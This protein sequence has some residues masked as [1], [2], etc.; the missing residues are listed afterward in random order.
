MPLDSET[1]TKEYALGLH[2]VPVAASTTIYSGALVCVN[3]SGNAIPA[4]DA[5]NARVIGRAQETVVNTGL[6]GA[7]TITV[8][9]G[10]FGFKNSASQACTNAHVGRR[11]FVADDETVQS[12][13]GTNSVIAGLMV[14]FEGTDVI[15]DTTLAAAL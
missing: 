11:V 13:T 7:L 2:H 14:G 8:K 1:N 6:A 9:R 4:A 5:A 3:A 15:V 10:V 12:A